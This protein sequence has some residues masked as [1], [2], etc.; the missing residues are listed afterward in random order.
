MRAF[1]AVTIYLAA[2]L[3]CLAADDISGR[4]QGQA[5]VP[6][7][8]LALTVDLAKNAAGAWIGSIIIPD[9]N[10][11]GAPLANISAQ[12]GRVAFAIKSNGDASAGQAA[13]H[14]KMDSAETMDGDFSLGGN[15]AKFELKKVG[16]A[17]VDLPLTS[18]PLDKAF[19]GKWI[20]EYVFADVP[21]HVTMTFA[22]NTSGGASAKFV[23]VGKK[24]TDVPVDLVRQDAALVVVQS[25]AYQI[26]YEGRLRKDTGQ[27]TGTFTQGPYEL[28]LNLHR[29][30]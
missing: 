6:G 30:P 9:L 12:D 15:T 5:Q 20:G 23:I 21:R 14:G 11:K 29:E 2:S 13:F 24:T 17:S 28:P 26:T 25:N 1:A 7:R 10:M 4:W 3:P 8:P 16:A 22:N 18:T 27:I 19:E